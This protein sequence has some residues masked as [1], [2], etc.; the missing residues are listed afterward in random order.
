MIDS[1]IN[2]SVDLWNWFPLGWQLFLENLGKIIL[3]V[4]PLM[5]AVAYTTY[6]ERKIISYI[7]VRIGPNRVGPRGWLQPIAD[8]VK[9]MFKEIVLPTNANRFLFLFAPILSIG[10]ALAA[11]AV[12]PFDR[13]MVLTD[14][15][16]GLLYILALTSIG[17]YGVI[18]AGWAS[19]S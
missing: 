2:A 16:A 10:P 6:A 18:I 7:Q 12:I 15:D 9:L 13:G 19:N 5:L 17:V 1:I 8:A 4:L 11:W 14:L 3:I